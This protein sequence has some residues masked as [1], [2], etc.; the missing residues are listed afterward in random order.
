[1]TVFN[2]EY[3]E[4]VYRPNGQKTNIVVVP[5]DDSVSLDVKLLYICG[6]IDPAFIYEKVG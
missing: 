2:F 6:T 1:M 3:C 4:L 5:E